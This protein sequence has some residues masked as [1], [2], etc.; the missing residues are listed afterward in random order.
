MDYLRNLGSAL[1]QKSGLNLPF[2]LGQKVYSFEG[3]YSLHDAI[4]R[5]SK[6]P[7]TASL[8]SLTTFSGRWIPCFRL[9]V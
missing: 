8:P 2:S 4:K 7:L 1:V 6:L 3:L 9:R 5:V